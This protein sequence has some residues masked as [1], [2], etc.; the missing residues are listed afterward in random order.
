MTDIIK[1]QKNRIAIKRNIK[2]ERVIN[3]FRFIN[4]TYGKFYA[5]MKAGIV[6]TGII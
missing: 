2:L 4:Y 6:T 1:E 3:Y 5:I